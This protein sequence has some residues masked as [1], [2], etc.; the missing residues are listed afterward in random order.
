MNYSTLVRRALEITYQNKF[1]WIFGFFAAGAGGYFNFNFSFPGQAPQISKEQIS[2][3]LEFFSRYWFVFV[4]LCLVLLLIFVVFFVL[5]IVSRTALI[6]CVN[7]IEEREKTNFKDGFQIGLNKFWK[8]FGL[9]LL[10]SLAVF[11]TFVILA[12]P[13]VS[14]FVLKMPVRGLILLLLAL[15][16]FIPFVIVFSFVVVYGQRELVLKNEG[17]F[18]SLSLGFSLLKKNILPTIV[19]ALILMLVSFAIGFFTLILFL[20]VFIPALILGI[21]FYFAAGTLGSIAIA[22]FSLLAMF[23]ITA[24]LSSLYNAFSSSLW[25]LTHRELER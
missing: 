10:Y 2:A 1:L 4:F 17:V 19:I 24:F 16:I 12:L 18:Q 7:K 13:T 14:L 23:V 9:G 6:A 11:L 25:T 3:A 21:V 22:I 20:L 5:N 15:A 8:M